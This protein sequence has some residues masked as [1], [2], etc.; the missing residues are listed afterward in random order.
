MFKAVGK[1]PSLV[2]YARS[3]GSSRNKSE[4]DWSAMYV[5]LNPQ[6]AAETLGYRW[7]SGL[8]EAVLLGVK[9]KAEA[10]LIADEFMASSNEAG[11]DKAKRVK[12]MLGIEGNLMEELGKRRQ[13]LL[14]LESPGEWELI[15]PHAILEQVIVSEVRSASF[16]IIGV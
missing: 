4:S 9:I 14:C 10:V 3:C 11:E 15:I 1:E 6:H 2:Q 7:D 12:S 16:A 8:T 13:C 5:Q